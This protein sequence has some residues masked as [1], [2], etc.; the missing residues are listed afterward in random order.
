LIHLTPPPNISFGYT[1]KDFLKGNKRL[2][3]TQTFYCKQTYTSLLTS[4]KEM[5]DVRFVSPILLLLTFNTFIGGVRSHFWQ[6]SFKLPLYTSEELTKTQFLSVRLKCQYVRRLCYEGFLNVRHQKQK[7]DF[8]HNHLNIKPSLTE[9]SNISDKNK[10][11]VRSF[12]NKP[13]QTNNKYFIGLTKARPLLCIKN[14]NKP[15]KASLVNK[16]CCEAS[17]ANLRFVELLSPHN[18]HFLLG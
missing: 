10:V 4:P 14:S 1:A 11:F 2:L 8:L 9:T 12:L 3:L 6:I 18:V 15:S 5:S 17:F 7:I 13:G 16:R